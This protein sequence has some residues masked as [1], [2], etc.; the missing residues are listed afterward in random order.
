MPASARRGVWSFIFEGNRSPCE[1]SRR[2]WV[3]SHNILVK[4]NPSYLSRGGGKTECRCTSRSDQDWLSG[5]I[6]TE[7]GC[8]S[9]YILINFTIVYCSC[10]KLLEENTFAWKQINP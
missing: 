1:A 2:F 4:I 7:D 5:R 10:T 8:K 3:S 9:K 6:E